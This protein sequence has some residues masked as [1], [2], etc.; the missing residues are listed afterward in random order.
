MTQIG[1]DSFVQMERAG[2]KRRIDM[3]GKAAAPLE[4]AAMTAEE[5]LAAAVERKTRAERV[6][7]LDGACGNNFELRTL[8]DGLLRS[9]EAAGSFLEQPIVGA[10]SAGEVTGD[11]LHEGSSIVIGPCFKPPEHPGEP[12]RNGHAATVATIVDGA[13][14]RHQRK[15]ADDA[16]TKAK[17]TQAIGE[18]YLGLGLV[19]KS[20]PLFEEARDLFVGASAV[21]TPTRSTR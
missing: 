19:R 2:Q 6:A 12:N 7:Y 13:V 11:P 21:N 17:M 20:V 5:I 18:S 9:H 4:S 10:L 14:D 15:L 8:L 1:T 16:V 3:R